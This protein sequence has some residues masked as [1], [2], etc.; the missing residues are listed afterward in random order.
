MIETTNRQ[1]A[2]FFRPGWLVL[3]LLLFT[4][5]ACVTQQEPA[6]VT[7]RG[8][9]I[10]ED[11]PSSGEEELAAI[12]A[13]YQEELSG[14]MNEVVGRLPQ[15]M[16]KGSPESTL[17]NWLA[18]LLYTEAAAHFN[19]P[20]SFAVQNAGGIRVPELAAGPLTVGKVYEL[21]PFDNTLVL[22]TMSGTVLQRFID[23]MAA[24]GGWP[25]SKQLRYTIAGN[26]AENITI[27]GRPLDP[28]ATY[29]IALPD[30]VANG[31]SDSE[32]LVGTEQVDD[33]LLLREVIIEH[34]RARKD[35]PVAALE[36]GRVK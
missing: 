31:G 9:G 12:I 14:Q 27:D 18:D 28:A 30:Y 29:T 4:L 20:I 34:L 7:A 33:G 1:T 25:V 24:G 19:R 6:A 32:M 17:G 35:E 5:P 13:P 2:S 15:T 3:A 22:S 11:L 8:Y 10:D 26:K 36:D 23:H 16:R 21:M